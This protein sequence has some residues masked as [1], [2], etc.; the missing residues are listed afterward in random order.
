MMVNKNNMLTINLNTKPECRHKD[1]LIEIE[2]HYL[3]FNTNQDE[4]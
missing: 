4:K 1:P 2:S 3:G